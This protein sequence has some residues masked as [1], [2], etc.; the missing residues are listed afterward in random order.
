MFPGIDQT[1]SGVFFNPD[2]TDPMNNFHFRRS[3]VLEVAHDT[4]QILGWVVGLSALAALLYTGVRL[5]RLLGLPSRAW[6]FLVVAMLL[7]PVIMTNAVFKNLWDRARPHQLEM[8]GGWAQYTPPL[9]MAD[10]CDRNCSFVSGDAALMFYFH[11]FAYLVG[12]RRRRAVFYGGLVLGGLAGVM[13]IMMGAHFFSDVVFAGILVVGTT[14]ASHALVFGPR[15]TV[16]W[17][18]ETVLA[19]ASAAAAI[20]H[21]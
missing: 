8:F 14:A 17:W 3:P 10:Q 12:Q 11:S 6:L 9:M 1:V 21:G 2:H 13:R 20:R 16:Q 7:G 15:A 5:R 4:V 19:P 18:R